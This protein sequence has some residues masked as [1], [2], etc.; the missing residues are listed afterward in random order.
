MVFHG[1]MHMYHQ[2]PPHAS[3]FGVGK[4]AERFADIADIVVLNASHRA[5]DI[6]PL[7]PPG[8]SIGVTRAR[9]P[10]CAQ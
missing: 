7:N 8:T 5:C 3:C 1:C 4:A 10:Q 2:H 6:L 9:P